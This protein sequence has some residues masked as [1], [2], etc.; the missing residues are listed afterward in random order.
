[1][2]DAADAGVEFVKLVDGTAAVDVPQNTVIQHEVVRHVERCTITRVVIGAFSI[3]QTS[4]RLASCNVVDLTNM[5]TQ[6][7]LLALTRQQNNG[8]ITA[9]KS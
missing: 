7:Q 1:M 4:K 8:F 3:M 6:L 9:S 5:L 2:K